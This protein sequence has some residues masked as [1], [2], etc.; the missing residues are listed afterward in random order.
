MPGLYFYD[1]A[2]VDIAQSLKPSDRGELEITDVNNAYLAEGEL[3]VVTL[4]RDFTWLDAGSA[5]SLLR[6]ASAVHDIQ[7]STG[8]QVACLEEIA[9]DM[10][11]IT[12]EQMRAAGESMKKTAYGEYILERVKQ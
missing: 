7:A 3:R 8:R 10:G 4:P 2:V 6:S 1:N 12:D 11:Y 9:R 5:E